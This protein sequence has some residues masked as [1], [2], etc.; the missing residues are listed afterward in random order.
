MTET[1]VIDASIAVKW[2]VEEEG[3][4]EALGLRQSFR[5]IAP[6]LL[7]VECANILWKKVQRGELS[8]EEAQLAASLLAR[9]DIELFGMRGLLVKATELAMEI[10]HP[11]YDCMYVSLAISRNCRFVTAD[12]R[13][14]RIL[15]QKAPRNIAD[16]CVTLEQISSGSH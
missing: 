14:L 11:A 5:F 13:L 10:G 2:V 9:G 6:E 3:T 8:R 4:P 16:L 12:E 15:A 1:L 7:T